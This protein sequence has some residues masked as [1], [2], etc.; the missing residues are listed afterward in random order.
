MSVYV[1]GINTRV[2]RSVLKIADIIEVSEDSRIAIYDKNYVGKSYLGGNKWFPPAATA[3]YDTSNICVLSRVAVICDA[4]EGQY[5]AWWVY[6]AD[7][8]FF[9]RIAEH[10]RLG[11]FSEVGS[12]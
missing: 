5:K 11:P 4:K 10:L 6:P 8:N 9:I 1:D 12:S 2:R 3:L 7:P